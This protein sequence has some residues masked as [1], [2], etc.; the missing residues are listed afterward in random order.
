[1]EIEINIFR[2]VT[3]CY[4]LNALLID[5]SLTLFFHFISRTCPAD[6]YLWNWTTLVGQRR[7]FTRNTHFLEREFFTSVLD[8]P[9]LFP[10]EY[11]YFVIKEEVTPFNL[12][13]FELSG[14]LGKWMMVLKSSIALM[15]I[16][17]IT[18]SK[19]RQAQKSKSYGTSEKHFL[20]INFYQIF[21][22]SKIAN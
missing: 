13:Y 4:Y 2:F 17:K 14:G 5:W 15:L 18:Q 21:I 6:F 9:L 20:W 7:R 22:Q 11:V 3:M 1:M 8:T 16:S 12:R 19:Y 10:Y